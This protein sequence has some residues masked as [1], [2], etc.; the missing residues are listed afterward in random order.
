MAHHPLSDARV[1]R[2]RVLYQLHV[3]VCRCINSVDP[4]A[5]ITVK[6]RR[7]KHPPTDRT[8]HIG[9]ICKR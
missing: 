1:P 3:L 7:V 5:R 6:S 9:R 2:A 4:R 8:T